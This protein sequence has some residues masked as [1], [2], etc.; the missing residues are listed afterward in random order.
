MSLALLGSL[1]SWS[2]MHYTVGGS[3]MWLKYG[4]MKFENERERMLCVEVVV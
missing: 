2:W 1:G 4:N 3:N